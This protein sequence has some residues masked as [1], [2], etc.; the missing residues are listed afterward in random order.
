MTGAYRARRLARGAARIDLPETSVRV[1]G[2]EVVIRPL[3][4]L[5]SRD[6]V[7][8][9][10]LMAGEA[11]ARFAQANGI[12]IP[13]AMQPSP[14]EVRQPQGIR[15]GRICQRDRRCIRYSARHIRNTIM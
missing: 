15:E 1:V 4:K 2:D 14:E 5:A 7:T 13:Y 3:P 8:D 10:M 6:M 12:V 11:A 9:A